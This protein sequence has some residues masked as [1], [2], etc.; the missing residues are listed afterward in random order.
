MAAVVVWLFAGVWLVVRA[1]RTYTS[2]IL[3]R[4]RVATDA[5]GDN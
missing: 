4:R 3:S 1:D 2:Y 5:A